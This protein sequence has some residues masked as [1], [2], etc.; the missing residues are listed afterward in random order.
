MEKDEE[1]SSYIGS[2]TGT[3]WGQKYDFIIK[4]MKKGNSNDIADIMVY[5]KTHTHNTNIRDTW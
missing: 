5:C 4:I 1:E 3:L 2:K